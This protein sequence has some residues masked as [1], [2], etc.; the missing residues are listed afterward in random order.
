ILA[1]CKS[2]NVW[3]MGDECY[4]HFVYQPHKPYSIAS[5]PGAK[6]RVIIINSMSKTFAM[7]RWHI[8]YTLEPKALIQAL[9]KLQSQSTS[10]PTSIAQYAA[11][12]GMT[13]TITTVPMML[14]EYTK[15]RKRII[16]KLRTISGITCEW[17]GGAFY[18]FPNI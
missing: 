8:G 4:S 11:L 15:Q 7:T 6:E 10:N 17:P 5:A 12:E 18:A 1:L 16:E 3:L 13:G 9:I 14:T 2:H